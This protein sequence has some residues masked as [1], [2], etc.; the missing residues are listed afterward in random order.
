MSVERGD[1]VVAV[2][3]FTDDS[4]GR[5]VLVITRPDT[6][7]HGEQSIGLLLPT[8]TGHAASISLDPDDW[9]DGGAPASRSIMPWS[10][11]AITE[12]WIDYRQGSLREGVGDDAVGQLVEYVQ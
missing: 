5:P 9:I 3:P 4:S 11:N 12:T 7:F 10:V 8:R 2:D 6:P 1:V